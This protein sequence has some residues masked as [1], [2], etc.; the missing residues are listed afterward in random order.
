MTYRIEAWIVRDGQ[1]RTHTIHNVTD[2]DAHAGMRANRD[3]D[4]DGVT[5]VEN[6]TGTTWF[7]FWR[8]VTDMR[9]IPDVMP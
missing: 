4:G 2:H 1:P 8:E 5:F 7:Y 3:R 9:F 6:E